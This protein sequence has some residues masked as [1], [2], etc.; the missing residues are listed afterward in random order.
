MSSMLWA[1]TGLAEFGGNLRE[2]FA[3][4]ALSG[5][6][7]LIEGDLNLLGG[8]VASILITLVY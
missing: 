2:I 8:Q 4:S 6:E 1:C 7:G 5:Y 3:M